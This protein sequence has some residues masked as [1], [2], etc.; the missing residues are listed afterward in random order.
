MK[1]IVVPNSLEAMK[2][3]DL[4]ECE[5]NELTETTFDQK[6]YS[7]LWASGIL[8]SFNQ[9]LD[10]LI[11]DYED[12]SISKLSDLIKARDIVSKYLLEKGNS[13][14]INSLL[15]QINLAISNNTGVFF[16]F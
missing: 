14:V 3:I 6:E 13:Q 9:K 1:T 16:Y 12:E 8:D 2:K 15:K 11:D 4:D 7:E 5:S 10:L